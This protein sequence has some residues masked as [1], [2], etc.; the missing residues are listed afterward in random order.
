MLI[1][2]TPSD[3][4]VSGDAGYNTG[5][6]LKYPAA[7][8]VI[9]SFLEIWVIDFEFIS[10]G[11]EIY[12]P[13]CCVAWELKS[14]KK[15][16]WWCDE[17]RAMEQ[18]P[19]ECGSD[20]VTVAFFASAEIGCFAALGWPLPKNIIDLFCEHRTETNGIFLSAGNGLLGALA[21][22]GLS[23][24]A[25][26]KKEAMRNLILSG[27]PWSE[28]EK[29]KILDY[30]EEDV[31][32]TVRLLEAM[33]PKLGVNNK[34]LGHAVMRGRYMASVGIMQD[35]GIPV[36]LPLLT[37]LRERWTD[38]Q[39]ALISAIDQDYQVYDGRRFVAAKFA[40]YLVRAGIPWPRTDS[41]ALK[42]DDET[43]RQMAKSHPKVSALR[44]LRH[45][46]GAMR[47]NTLQVGHDGRART[48]LSPFS[49]KTGR[50]QPSTSKYIF[51]SATW[52]RGLIR[53]SVDMAVAYL[54]FGSQ[55]IAI[56]AAL[57]GDAAMW[58]AYDSG[59]PYM[60]FAIDAKLA[61]PGATKITHGAIR[62]RCKAIVLGVG[63]G[64]GHQ[65]MAQSAGISEIEASQLL[66]LH[67][68]TYR[69]FWAWS[70][71]NVNA[72][73]QGGELTTA[74]GFRIRLDNNSTP[75]TRSLL[76]WP[77][78]ANGAE[79]L[80]LACVKILEKGV[81]LCAPIHDAV[82]IEAPLELIDEHVEIARQAMIWASKMVLNG[83]TCRVDADIYR[84]PERYMD[85]ERGAAM[86]NQ[87]MELI[88]EPI[89]SP[90]PQK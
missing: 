53:P 37:K 64:M 61:P 2:S 47:L 6:L 70:E 81:K 46:L 18:A 49:A 16:K 8:T 67:R 45:S 9:K 75:N 28:S 30:C 1:Q 73:L 52:M 36:D 7:T 20:A 26:I 32:A 62:Q 5:A 68:E 63:Y 35:H 34:R 25:S 33:A 77:M 4:E 15:K 31:E 50:N 29:Q 38:I 82:L 3:A 17:L 90:T 27:G 39:D 43:F 19:W 66:N 55:E 85:A 83:K 54:D 48:M 79:M 89:W 24:M 21:Y 87:V 74:F 76:N 59:D 88:G 72:A 84:Y 14:G 86:W 80:R 42:L 13:I 41:G 22:Y 40:D 51:G 58:R 23:A 10:S 57:S 71:A 78:Q 11:G 12:E 69:I 44:E 56:A 65:S 60:Q